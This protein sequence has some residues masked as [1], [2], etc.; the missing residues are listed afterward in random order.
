MWENEKRLRGAR[1]GLRYQTDL[2]DEEWRK[3]EPMIPP[4][5]NRLG[6]TF[7]S[8]L[9]RVDIRE[10]TNGLLYLLGAP[11][12]WAS[13]PKNLPAKSTLHYYYY[14]WTR[15]GTLLRLHDALYGPPAPGDTF[16]SPRGRRLPKNQKI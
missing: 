7:T 13:L 4:P 9:R 5:Q 15:D 14:L 10:V 3:I 12:S 6:Q 8:K 2:T 1:N 16:P 11:C